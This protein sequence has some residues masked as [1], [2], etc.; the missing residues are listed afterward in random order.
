MQILCK[1]SNL[2]S[3]VRCHVCGQ[4]FLVY[5]TRSAPDERE[6]RHDQIVQ[7]LREHH[8]QDLSAAAHPESAFHMPEWDVDAG[9][10]ATEL[11]GGASQW[12][13]A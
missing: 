6:H 13:C 10:S 1:A 7:A 9:F 2:V 3:D 12:A 11:V 4:G 5:W 8:R